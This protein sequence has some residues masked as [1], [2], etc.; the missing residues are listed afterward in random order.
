MNRLEIKNYL[1][2]LSQYLGVESEITL[3]RYYEDL[4]SDSRFLE[5]LNKSICGVTGFGG[6]Q[7]ESVVDLHAYR[8]LLYIFTRA[9]QP[10]VFIETGVLNGFSSAC[11]LLAMEHNNIG[12][13]VSI[14]L[15]STEEEIL[16]QGTGLLPDGKRTGWVIPDFL[17]HR[18][19]LRLGRA[20]FLLPEVFEEVGA[21]D[22]FLHDS[23]HC[24]IHMMLEMCMAYK[25]IR[26]KGWILSDNIEQNS[27][28]HD[29]AR[30]I[31]GRYLVISSFATPDRLWQHGIV[32]KP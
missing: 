12:R 7:F 32:Q 2:L 24:Y 14:D 13:L 6:K 19:S 16:N 17:K 15:P 10:E 29:F 30:A 4:L 9:T 25:F 18:H 26:T 20:E 8:S 3:N 11:I 5:S 28:F 1:P 31:E 21:A 27:A 22:V 23:D